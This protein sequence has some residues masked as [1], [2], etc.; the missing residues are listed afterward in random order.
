MLEAEGLVGGAE[1]LMSM[2]TLAG[3][4]SISCAL[5]RLSFL[6]GRRRELG[7]GDGVDETEGLI[8]REA[9]G[10]L[11]SDSFCNLRD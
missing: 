8:S 6:K 3:I 2:T 1:A 4:D 5:D 10:R 11:L 9:L 7:C